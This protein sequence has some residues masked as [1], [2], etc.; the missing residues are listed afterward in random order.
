MSD[1]SQTNYNPFANQDGTINGFNVFNGPLIDPGTTNLMQPSFGQVWSGSPGSG[2]MFDA[3]FQHGWSANNNYPAVQQTDLTDHEDNDDFYENEIE[4]GK[5]VNTNGDRNGHVTVPSTPQT[6]AITLPGSIKPLQSVPSTTAHLDYHIKTHDNHTT[7]GPLSKADATSRAAELREKLLANKRVGSV[8]PVPPAA[9]RKPDVTREANSATQESKNSASSLGKPS[10]SHSIEFHDKSQ[11]YPGTSSQGSARISK[12]SDGNC[13]TNGARKGDTSFLTTSKAS[14]STREQHATDITLQTTS[15]VVATTNGQQ[16]DKSLHKPPNVPRSPSANAD[17]EGLIGEYRVPEASKDRALPVSEARKANQPKPP[18]LPSKSVRTAAPSIT[19]RRSIGSAESGE[20]RSDQESEIGIKW[21]D[22][23]RSVVGKAKGDVHSGPEKTSAVGIP[24]QRHLPDNRQPG[25]SRQASVPQAPRQNSLSYNRDRR[26]ANQ[27]AS[28]PRSSTTVALNPA[29]ARL[30]P[31]VPLA[32]RIDPVRKE[33]VQSPS[34]RGPHSIHPQCSD[35][36]NT[37]KEPGTQNL[38]DPNSVAEMAHQAPFSK[39]ITE[40]ARSQRGHDQAIREERADAHGLPIAQHMRIDQQ[41]Q[42]IQDRTGDGNNVPILTTAQ[43]QQLCKLGVDLRPEGFND[44]C[45]FLE[46]HKFH[47]PSY[48]NKALARRKQF[49]AIEAEERALAAKRFALERETQLEF[50][51]FH[52]GPAHFLAPHEDNRPLEA[53][54]GKPMPPPLNLVKKSADEG[55]ATANIVTGSTSATGSGCS[56]LPTDTPNPKRRHVDDEIDL[57]R[58]TK[59][60][61]VDYDLQ[62]Y[63]RSRQAS[64]RTFRGEPPLRERRYSSDYRRFRDERSRSPRDRRRSLSPLAYRRERSVE[65]R[66]WRYP[67]NKHEM[68]MARMQ[69]LPSPDIP[70]PAWQK[71][72]RWSTTNPF[73][74]E[75]ISVAETRFNRVGHLKNAFNEGQAVLIGRDGQEIEGVCGRELCAL[76]DDAAREQERLEMVY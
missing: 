13:P 32:Q 55:A 35:N 45:A 22:Q 65:P 59:V 43:Y 47:I 48:R 19:Q 30:S 9:T 56:V 63:E 11:T 39:P 58:S 17:I 21:R 27:P 15:P 25:A 76:I 38:S 14:P 4:P 71:A 3:P 23:G 28:E 41:Q 20:I 67:E 42:E 52:M 64:P 61:R 53:P 2:S 69:S 8:T 7:A 72:L 50:G 49:Q 57:G 70:S 5:P 44:L 24:K 51:Q 60:A 31:D 10:A 12:A 40:V 36:G 33:A 46:H 16:V 73:R 74:I 1:R 18:S 68:F 37:G 6:Q 34:S 75:W 26:S 29:A 62:S 66:S 54:S